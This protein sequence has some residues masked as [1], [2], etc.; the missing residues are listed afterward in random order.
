MP[1][2]HLRA[3]VMNIAF[4]PHDACT[5][6]PAVLD[7]PAAQVLI[8]NYAVQCRN[9]LDIITV[10]PWTPDVEKISHLW[11]PNTYECVRPQRN[12]RDY[13]AHH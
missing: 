10:I 8:K 9:K 6:D 1:A 13:H 2:M 3:E 7:A 11:P 4:A 12:V 5:S